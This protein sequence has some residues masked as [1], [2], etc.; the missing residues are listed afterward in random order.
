ME[1]ITS[2]KNPYIINIRA[3]E[4]DADYRYE[5]GEF[6]CD[7]LK[8][9]KEAVLFG[10]EITSVL[11]KGKAEDMLPDVGQYVVPDDLFEYISPMKN[12]PGPLFTVKIPEEDWKTGIKKAIILETVQDPGNVG[13]VIRSAGAFN[14]DAVILCNGCADPFSPKA[15]RSTMG[16]V[17]RQRIIKTDI[18]G[19]KELL[20]KNLL[21]LY[22]AAL[23]DKAES[24]EGLNLSA[25]AVAIGSE[26]QGLSRGML[27]ICEKEIIIPMNENSESL[28]A[29]VAS[30]V[31]MWEMRDRK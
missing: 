5:A 18:N 20:D 8:L 31:I 1:K 10:A 15:V 22:G 12:S 23:S 13:T 6:V 11:W 7:G 28:N 25:C 24:I 4:K 3:L 21:P 27:D 30:A 17:F 29:A 9:L 16:A 26:G 14:I 2:R 19:T